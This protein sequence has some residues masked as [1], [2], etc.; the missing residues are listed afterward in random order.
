MFE[1]RINVLNGNSEDTEPEDSNVKRVY[2]IDEIQA[3]LGVSKSTTYHLAN[4]GV[5]HCLKVGG[6]YRIPKKSFDLWLEGKQ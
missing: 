5:F 3:I 4:S 6:H 1:E 2:T